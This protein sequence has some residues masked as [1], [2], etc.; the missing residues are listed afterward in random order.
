MEKSTEQFIERMGQRFERDGL[1]RIA[2][3]MLAY[4]LLSDR[5]RSLDEMAEALQVSK[6]SASTNARLLQRQGAVDR[7]TRPGDRKD[8]YEVLESPYT[9]MLDQTL[10][11]LR[12]LRDLLRS[13]LETDE[14]RDVLVR[15][16]LDVF[17]E[18][19][20]R[21]LEDLMATQE[22][23]EERDAAVVRGVEAA[24]R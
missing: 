18:F 14:A 23:W 24:S 3:R 20:H 21:V 12:E 4:L 10:V 5:E 1:P 22:R 7:V 16:R 8:Y 15:H 9:G 6:A 19:F 2:G 13:G 17:A 11:R